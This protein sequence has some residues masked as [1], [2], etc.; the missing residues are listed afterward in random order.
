LVAATPIAG[1]SSAQSN[2]GCQATALE[3][4]PRTQLTCP[5]GVTIVAEDGTTF[6]LEDRDP[7]APG[8][9]AIHLDGQ[10]VMVEVQPGGAGFEVNAPQAIAAVR[11]TRWVVDVNGG[12][13]SVLVMEGQV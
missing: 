9:D 4:P 11:G 1:V 13:T 6:S 12:S 10:A 7:S 2:G 8:P 3:N 5:N